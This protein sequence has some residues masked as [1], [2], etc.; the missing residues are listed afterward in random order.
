MEVDMHIHTIES[1]GTYT[2]EEI[3]VRAIKNNVIALAITDHDTVSG[4]E[5]GKE[6]ADKYGMEFIKGIEISCNEDN[7]EIHILGYFLNLDDKKF[8]SELMNWKRLEIKEIE[9]L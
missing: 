7:L 4:V 6:I 1:D 2:P 3:I 9:K 5:K 8:L